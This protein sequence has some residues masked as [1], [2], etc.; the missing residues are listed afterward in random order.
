MISYMES[1]PNIAVLTPRVLNE[2]GS[3][4]YLPKKRISVHYLLSGL[5]EGFGGVQG[6]AELTTSMNNV[7]LE[8]NHSIIQSSWL[9]FDAGLGLEWNKYRF[10]GS[11]VLWDATAAPNA[12]ALGADLNCT[13][14]LKTRYVTIPLSLSLGDRDGWHIELTAL[15]GLGWTGKNTGLRRQYGNTNK[16]KDYSVNRSLA[17]YKLDLRAAM[18]YNGFGI[19]FQVATLSTLRDGCQELFPVKFGIIL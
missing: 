11:E 8:F 18:M 17:P 16:E 10:T 5:F 15:P 13:S 9:R 4:Q 14:R 3:E 12:F 2:D 7:Q 1:H 19:Y 6:P